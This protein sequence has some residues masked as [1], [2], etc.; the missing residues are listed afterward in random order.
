MKAG[1]RIPAK[2]QPA[3]DALYVLCTGRER[4]YRHGAKHHES[5]APAGI[6][7]DRPVANYACEGPDIWLVTTDPTI[8]RFPDDH[9]VL[10]YVELVAYLAEL[11]VTIGPKTI[12]RAPK[13]ATIPRADVVA[14]VD[15]LRENGDAS[16]MLLSDLLAIDVDE[17]G[18]M[19]AVAA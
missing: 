11:G 15:L 5:T 7:T 19:A 6:R 18:T 8:D 14:A 9:P 13:V 3:Y 17:L 2:H 16:W 10:T 12:T 1:Y 4:N